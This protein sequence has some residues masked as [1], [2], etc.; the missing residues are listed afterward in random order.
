M[1]RRLDAMYPREYTTKD[2]KKQTHWIKAGVAWESDEKGQTNVFLHVLP[3]FTVQSDG[4][5]AVR[6]QLREPLPER[7]E[8]PRTSRPMVEHKRQAGSFTSK[9]KHQEPGGE[10]DIPF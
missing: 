6:V 5:L 10:D 7:E 4:S 1:S 2:G 8:G 3:P 9:H